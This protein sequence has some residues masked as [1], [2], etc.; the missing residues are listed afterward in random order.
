M[1]PDPIDFDALPWRTFEP[2][3]RFKSLTRDKQRLRLVELDAGFSERHWCAKGHVGLVL[4]GAFELT[5]PRGKREY[6]AGQGV[7]LLPGLAEKHKVRVIG[8]KA[9]V[10]LVEPE[11]PLPHDLTHLDGHPEHA[12]ADEPSHD[13]SE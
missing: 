9:R 2:G 3:V 7:F 13:A 6:R 12:H 1:Y 10:I 11:W 8:E 4:E 5:F